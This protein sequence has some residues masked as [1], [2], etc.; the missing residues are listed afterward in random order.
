LR[1]H[2]GNVSN[3][4]LGTDLGDPERVIEIFQR[5]ESGRTTTPAAETLEDIGW[6]NLWGAVDRDWFIGKMKAG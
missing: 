1:K 4:S 5:L 6:R 3:R 2:G